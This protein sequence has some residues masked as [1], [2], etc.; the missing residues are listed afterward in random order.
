MM[1]C[2]GF[3]ESYTMAVPLQILKSLA[4]DFDGKFIAPHRGD[5]V[6][7]IAELLG[8]ANALLPIHVCV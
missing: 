6:L 3:T 2:I 1:F 8:K 7:N 5:A 4:A